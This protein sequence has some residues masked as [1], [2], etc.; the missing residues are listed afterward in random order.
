MAIS[1]ISL[2]WNV[3]QNLL[4]PVTSCADI[5]TNMYRYS[6]CCAVFKSRYVYSYL[7]CSSISAGDIGSSQAGSDPFLE[8]QV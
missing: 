3:K 6:I 2:E 1:K 5:D 8:E 4:K 7:R